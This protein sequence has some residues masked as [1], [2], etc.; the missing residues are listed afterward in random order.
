M[1]LLLNV[2][3]IE[4]SN[5]IAISIIETEPFPKAAVD[6]GARNEIFYA[7]LDSSKQVNLPIEGKF[8]REDVSKSYM[9]QFKMIPEDNIEILDK[10]EIDK[11]AEKITTKMF[12]AKIKDD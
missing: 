12:G 9:Q 1:Q 2:K 4:G 3:E 6:L 11:F 10:A 7:S 8:I 5:K